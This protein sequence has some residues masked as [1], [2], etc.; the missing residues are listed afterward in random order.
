MKTACLGAAGPAA[1]PKRISPLSCVGQFRRSARRS[2][3][4]PRRLP[5][6]VMGREVRAVPGRSWMPVETASG[7]PLDRAFGVRER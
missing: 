3:P 2:G 4:S 5:C 1:N 7:E 6:A